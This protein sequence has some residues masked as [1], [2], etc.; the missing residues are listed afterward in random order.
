MEKDED[1]FY[2]GFI[3]P[4]KRRELAYIKEQLR[5]YPTPIS[6]SDEQFNH[7]L[8]ERDRLQRELPNTPLNR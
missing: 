3:I 7:L 8:Q 6:D 4:S 5:N 2:E 1:D